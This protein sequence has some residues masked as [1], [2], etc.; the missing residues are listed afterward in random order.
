MIAQLPHTRLLADRI[1]S[2]RLNS[3]DRITPFGH[4]HDPDIPVY[5]SYTLL[6]Q[7]KA[8]MNKR[9]RKMIPTYLQ[10]RMFSQIF[11]V[12]IPL[13]PLLRSQLPSCRIPS[14]WMD[15]LH[16]ICLSTKLNRHRDTSPGNGS[17]DG[18]IRLSPLA[19]L[20]VPCQ[21]IPTT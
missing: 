6:P 2:I 18:P 21:P 10:V 19:H 9:F 1:P 7:K 15:G 11:A 16:A 14:C 20:H 17:P 4:P 3:S 5:D 12:C 13:E 8:C